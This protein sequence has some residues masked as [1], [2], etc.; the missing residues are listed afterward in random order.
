MAREYVEAGGRKV[1]VLRGTGD[2][3]GKGMALQLNYLMDAGAIEHN[4]STG[5]FKVHFD[6]MKEQMAKLT[7]EIMT[8][9]AE[10]N[11]AKAKELTATKGLHIMDALSEVGYND[12]A[13]MRGLVR[14]E[15]TGGR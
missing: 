13:M 1:A 11:Y 12:P 2:A 9:Q 14:K 6:R 15:L 5:T 7:G 3:H 4:E 10:G 8:A